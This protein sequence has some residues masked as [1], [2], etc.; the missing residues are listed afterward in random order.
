MNDN[1]AKKDN[2]LFIIRLALILFLIVFISTL[3]LTLCN[4]L[5]KDKIAALEQKTANEAR[6]AVIPG[7]T[8]E[9]IKL[10]ESDEK[11]F[12]DEYAFKGAYRAEKD[13][14]FSGYCINVAPNGFGGEINMIVGL[15]ENLNY[16]GIKIISL[17]ETPGLGAKASESEF[18][19]QFSDNK[20]GELEVIKNAKNTNEN[21]INAISGATITSKAVT[22]GVNNALKIAEQINNKE[23]EQN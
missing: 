8:F 16:T 6:Q 5:T 4:Y 9:E 22:T 23:A 18:T 13:G 7:A 10:S 20:K 15:D 17:S 14:K 3:L 12:S 19:K 11:K 21:Q 2:K 1:T